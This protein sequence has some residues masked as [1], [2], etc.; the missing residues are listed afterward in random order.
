MRIVTF[1][2]RYL[3]H[4]VLTQRYIKLKQRC[5]FWRRILRCS[6]LINWRI[7]YTYYIIKLSFTIVDQIHLS[8]HFFHRVRVTWD[9]DA[10]VRFPFCSFDFDLLG[11]DNTWFNRIFGSVLIW[12]KDTFMMTL[13]ILNLFSCLWSLSWCPFGYSCFVQ[14]IMNIICSAFIWSILL[15]LL[16]I[17]E[18]LRFECALLNM[19]FFLFELLRCSLHLL[20]LTPL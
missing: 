6:L 12:L 17:I 18:N 1:I 16:L 20:F 14:V 11:L 9:I 19:H 5:L 4:F 13:L 7:G 8:T 15:H 2:D 10:D 3:S